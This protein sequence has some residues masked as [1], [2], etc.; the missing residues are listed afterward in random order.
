MHTEPF[1]LGDTHVHTSLGFFAIC[2][3]LQAKGRCFY[4][5][6]LTGSA[7]TG[8]YTGEGEL[9]FQDVVEESQR[10]KAKELFCSR[11]LLVLAPG[12]RRELVV[13]SG[14]NQKLRIAL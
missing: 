3:I 6:T 9:S 5:N 8:L 7:A 2:G 12:G 4:D 11:Y 14:C 1:I 13:A 10:N